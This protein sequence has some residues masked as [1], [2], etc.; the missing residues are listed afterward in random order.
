MSASLFTAKTAREEKGATAVEYGLLVALIAAIIVVAV[1]LLGTK[2]TGAF[3]S[4]NSK[5]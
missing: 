1:A 2:I 5:L 3:S 4:I